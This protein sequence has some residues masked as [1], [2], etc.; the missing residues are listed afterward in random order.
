MRDLLRKRWRALGTAGVL[1]AGVGGGTAAFGLP[2]SIDM[3][4]SQ[5]VKAFEAPMRQLPEGAVPQ[6]NALSP[7]THAFADHRDTTGTSPYPVTTAS[8]AE[9]ERLYGVYCVMCHGQGMELGTVMQP[10]RWPEDRRR[11]MPAEAMLMGYP[12]GWSYV[13]I[14]FGKAGPDSRA[15]YM[16]SYGWA[17]TDEEIWSVVHYVRRSIAPATDAGGR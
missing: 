5:A 14:R 10:G 8:I 3:A 12:E 11:G 17:M 16:P 7:R 4:D 1:L 6:A 13:K 2:W 9:G 15:Q